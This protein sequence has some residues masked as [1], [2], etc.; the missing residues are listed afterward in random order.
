VL[1]QGGGV[2][3][4]LRDGD[5]DARLGRGDEHGDEEGDAGRSTGGEE[6]MIGVG[7]MA[8]AI[9]GIGWVRDRCGGKG[10]IPAMNLATF[11]RMKGTPWL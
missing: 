10:D 8:I 1:G 11:L 9:W 2:K 3:R 6:D 7:W 5:E 4:V